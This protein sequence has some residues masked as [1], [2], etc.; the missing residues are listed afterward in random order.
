MLG[1]YNVALAVLGSFV[2][3][4]RAL[5]RTLAESVRNMQKAN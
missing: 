5:E 3:G 1:N 2:F 4:A